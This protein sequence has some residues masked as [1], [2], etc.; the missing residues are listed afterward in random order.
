MS[1][2]FPDEFSERLQ[3]NPNTLVFKLKLTPEF[4]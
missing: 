4:H 3:V 2:D 1:I